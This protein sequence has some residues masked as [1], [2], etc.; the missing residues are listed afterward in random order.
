MVVF[1]IHQLGTCLVLSLQMDFFQQPPS[2]ANVITHL[3]RRGGVITKK[4]TK[5]PPRFFSP[6]WHPP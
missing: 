3:T 1:F 5:S 2:V 4:I 6:I